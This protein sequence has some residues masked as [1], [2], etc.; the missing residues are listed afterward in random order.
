[1][2]IE[3]FKLMG[4]I[5]V[6]NYEAN[7]SIAKTDEKAENLG[8]KFLK[9]VGTAAKWGTAIA[10]AAAA[11]G[12]ALFGMANKA[13]GTTDRID[14]MSQK[15]GLSREAFQ[16]F[17]FICSQSGMSV[18]R[19]QGGFKTLTSQISSATEGNAAATEAFKTLGISMEDLKAMS[20]ED[21]FKKS[22]SAL[23]SVT[24]ETEKATLAN[25]LFG[26]AGSEM[27]PLLNGASGSVEEMAKKAHE[28]G[29]VL[30][31]DAIDSGVKF[32][33]TVDQ[34]KRSLGAIGDKIGI[35]VMPIVQRF[36]DFILDKMPIIQKVLGGVF[37]GIEVFVSIVTN[38]IVGLANIINNQFGWIID[39]V[40]EMKNAFNNSMNELDD[41][42]KAFKSMLKVIMGPIGDL[43]IFEEIGKIMSAIHEIMARVKGGEGIA[44]A[45]KA[46]FKWRDS[47]VGN[48]LI[49][50]MDYCKTIFDS[51]ES[52]IRTVIENLGPIFEGLKDLFSI[53]I[54]ALAT[55]WESFGKPIWDFFVEAIEKV[56]EVFNHV[57]H[58]LVDIFSGIC[59]TLKNLWE[60][61]LKPIFEAIGV[62]LE[63]VLL[64]IWSDSFF[65]I[66]DI[67]KGAF[68][69]IGTVWN[70]VLKPILD[71]IINFIGGIFSGNWSQIWDGIV[72]ILKG[73][74]GAVKMVIW[75][76]IEWVM[77]KISG[78]VESIVSPFRQAADSIGNIWSSIKSVFKLPHF[79]LEGS[80]NPLKWIDQGMPRIGV[81]WYYKGGIFTEPT[82]LPGGI[83]IGDRFNG[84][85]AN[86][87]AVV[88]LDSMYKNIKTII[89]DEN[90]NSKNNGLTLV[91]EKFINNREQDIEELVEEI[92]FFL[93]RK[94]MVT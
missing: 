63:T 58:I 64:P 57:F 26:K 61:V 39:K 49:D 29:L 48:V 52:I 5:L 8:S 13:A 69:F 6:N 36:F 77:N 44:E 94:G 80:L 7:K 19:L 67:V 23:Q 75:S 68:S 34:A 4:S 16:E 45:F 54:S 3:I 88:P 56:A 40:V 86:A 92:A 59:D 37:K 82:V 53:T 79:T 65:T 43:P 90:K 76:P 38:I 2:A 91:I 85:G 70:T 30:S 11:G 17:D 60:S 83:G 12:T 42:G 50:L 74:W 14:K 33:D 31:D 28:L 25:K 78:I 46:A 41:Y 72:G 93:K 66:G 24:N 87:E 51:I 71:G 18:D 55:T 84:K 20:R 9:G 35:S 47:G 1:M 21:I 27:M 15:I 81:D 32:T 89:A 10:G 22:I 62:F 73:I